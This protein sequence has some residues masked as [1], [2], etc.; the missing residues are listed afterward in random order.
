MKVIDVREC[1]GW[2]CKNQNANTS[3]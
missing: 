1:W 2:I 3:T